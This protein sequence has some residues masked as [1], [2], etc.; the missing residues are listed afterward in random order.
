MPWRIPVNPVL[1][2]TLLGDILLGVTLLNQ[3]VP[4]TVHALLLEK[5]NSIQENAFAD[6]TM[7][8]NHSLTTYDFTVLLK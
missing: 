5:N 6:I 1:E 7:T 4:T 2:E 8:S 3:I